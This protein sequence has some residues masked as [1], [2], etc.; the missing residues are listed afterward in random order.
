VDKLDTYTGLMIGY[1]I[2]SHSYFGAYDDNDYS[3]LT[4]GLQWS[5]FIGGRYYFKENIAVMLELGYG[6]AF[7]NLGVALKF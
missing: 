5:L 6:V 3:G 4:S 1:R 7:I 2:L